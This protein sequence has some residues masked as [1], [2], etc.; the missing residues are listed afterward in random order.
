MPFEA[1]VWSVLEAAGPAAPAKLQPYRRPI[2]DYARSR[3]V[4]PSEA[5]KIAERVLRA[6]CEPAFLASAVRLRLRFRPA[7][8][9]L[10]IGELGGARG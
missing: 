8:F 10:V 6:M 4:D 1:S 3:S 2:A 5:E 9:S 7:V